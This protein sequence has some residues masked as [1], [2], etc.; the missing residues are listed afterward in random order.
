LNGNRV[1]EA[2]ELLNLL[3]TA[4]AQAKEAV[5]IT[6]SRLDLPGPEILFVNPAFCE[7]TGFT[8]EEILLKTPRVLQGPKSNRA[9]L[10][11]LRNTLARGEPFSGETVNYR[12][13]GREYYVEWDI[14]PIRAGDGQV[15]YF[16]SIQ[17]DVTA[18]KAAQQQLQD[19]LEQLNKRRGDLMS[20]LNELRIGTAIT[21]ES[22]AVLFLNAVAQEIFPRAKNAS[23]DDWRKLF[24]LSAEDAQNIEAM[25]RKNVA[26][27]ARVPVRLDR[28]E[29]RLWLDIDVKDDPRDSRR[30][31]FFFYDVTEINDLRLLLDERAHFHDLVGKSAGCRPSTNRFATWPGS[32]QRF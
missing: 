24:D 2:G 1:L 29:R 9:M 13:D 18:R 14:T 10:Q 26:Q 25:L 30:K 27:R 5:V 16:L 11:E 15:A 31:I 32:M 12:H 22:G 19:T 4:V 21:D 3:E 28:G 6:S 17:R 23:D 7:M 8:R 20:I